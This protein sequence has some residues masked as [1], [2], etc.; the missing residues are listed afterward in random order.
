MIMVPKKPGV[1]RDDAIFSKENLESV[2]LRYESP[3]DVLAF[4]RS[5]PS[6]EEAVR[7]FDA[8]A[9]REEL[10][11]EILTLQHKMG[12]MVY[13][14]TL[15]EVVHPVFEWYWKFGYESYLLFMHFY[16]EA[17]WE[18]FAFDAAVARRKA[19]VVVQVYE[20]LDMVPL[21]FDWHGHLWR[22][23]SACIPRGSA[24]VLLSPRA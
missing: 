14:P 18:F 19:E 4:A 11:S 20:E 6:P 10:R 17:A 22:P 23:W 16:P 2:N 7:D 13:L 24:R 12:D 9:W 5:L 3:E 8:D 21:T 15:W 1:Y